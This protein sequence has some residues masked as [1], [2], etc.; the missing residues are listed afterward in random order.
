MNRDPYA[1]ALTS[2]LAE[3]KN[4]YPEINHSFLF[5]KTGTIIAEDQ[6]T[7]TKTMNN[8]IEF[9][10]SISKNAKIIGN[11]KSISIN[12]KNGK[13]IV[14]HIKDFYLVLETSKNADKTHIHSITNVIFPTI[15]KT[16]DAFVP[17]HLQHQSPK[18]LVVDTISG[19]FAGDS[20]Q[21]DTETLVEWIKNDDFSLS[22]NLIE[23]Q[24]LHEIIEH[25]RIETFAGNSM[26]C[27]VKAISDQ[28][29]NGK[30]MIRIPEKVCDTLAIK[31]GDIVTVKPLL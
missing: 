20:V 13:L 2:A 26:L 23:D 27:K 11:L 15:L 10:Q 22:D 17:I 28:Y 18:E 9:F 3:I 14:S 29:L 30:N 16:L 19:F 8:T 31:K 1:T 7:D 24:E 6:E 4:A 25:V 12:G 21:I 5:T